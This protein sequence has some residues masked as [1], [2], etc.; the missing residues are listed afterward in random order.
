[1]GQESARREGGA[2]EQGLPASSAAQAQGHAHLAVPNAGAG[3]RPAVTV[4]VVISLPERL[5]ER[6]RAIKCAYPGPEAGIPPHITLVSLAACWH[7]WADVERHVRAVAARHEPFRVE[8]GPAQT[9]LPV[10]P[11]T[12]LSV[13][14]GQDALQDLAEEMRSGPLAFEPAFPFVPH[15]TLLH[16]GT[17]TQLRDLAAAHSDFADAFTVTSIGLY[18]QLPDARWA[19]REEI[20]L[21]T[22]SQAAQR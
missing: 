20:P 9:F 5:T 6:I 17:E 3:C 4:G 10:S 7:E 11:V 12:Y 1:M 16:P 14:R 15:V 21:A 13:T 8:L 22:N 19:H 2:P 18:Q